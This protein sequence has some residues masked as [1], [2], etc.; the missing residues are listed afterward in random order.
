M[1]FSGL[2]GTFLVEKAEREFLRMERAM[3]K[4]LDDTVLKRASRFAVFVS[5]FVDG[6]APFIAGLFC[7]SPFFAATLGFLA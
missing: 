1:M 6:F 4:S 5:S 3:L 7:L 2:T